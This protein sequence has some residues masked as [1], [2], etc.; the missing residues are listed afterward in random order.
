MCFENC[1]K[2]NLI[3]HSLVLVLGTSRSNWGPEKILFLV[4]DAPCLLVYAAL[5]AAH[6][7]GINKYCDFNRR[8]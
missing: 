7:C 8:F 4:T 2:M 1:K 5:G 3:C 6:C